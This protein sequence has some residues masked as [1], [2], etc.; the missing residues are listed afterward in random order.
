MANTY[1]DSTFQQGETIDAIL[2][3]VNNLRAAANNG[4]VVAIA[5]GELAAVD[6]ATLFDDADETAY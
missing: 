3:A 4:K 5:N 1:Y 6:P 2:T